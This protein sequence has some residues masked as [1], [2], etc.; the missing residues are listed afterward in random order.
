MLHGFVC[1][2]ALGQAVEVL[3]GFVHAFFYKHCARVGSPEAGHSQHR[4]FLV[5]PATYHKAVQRYVAVRPQAYAD[6]RKIVLLKLID[7]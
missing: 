2:P 4:P 1:A 5:G 7:Y 6:S 3:H